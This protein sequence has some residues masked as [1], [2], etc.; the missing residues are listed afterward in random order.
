M[1][2]ILKSTPLSL[3]TIIYN[4]GD[5][6]EIIYFPCGGLISELATLTDGTTLE[7]SAI[8]REGAFGISSLF[9]LETSPHE[10]SIQVNGAAW[11]VTTN[12]LRGLLPSCPVFK[13]ELTRYF[14]ITF[15]QVSQIAACTGHHSLSQ[16][17]ASKLV[18]AHERSGSI[19]LPLTHES[20]GHVLGVR[21]AGVTNAVLEFEKEG[22]I[23]CGRGVITILNLP[24][25]KDA[26]CECCSMPKVFYDEFLKTEG[27]RA[28]IGIAKS[29]P[30]SPDHYPSIVDFF[31]RRN[32]N[33]RDRRDAVC[34]SL[35]TG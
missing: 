3:K 14:N 17:C 6:I 16:R 10:I 8:G 9:G 5:R 30:P 33:Q 32:N 29:R 25:L 19:E 7:V 21:R 26:A 18:S 12:L 22:L 28:S 34:Q 15:L 4:V 27:I 20:L 2:P 1:I 35:T 31:E 11:C 24:R 13:E 23:R